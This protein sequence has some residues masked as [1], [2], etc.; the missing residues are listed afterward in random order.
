MKAYYI[1]ILMFSLPLIILVYNQRNH[2]ITTH[3][4]TNRSLC[5]CYLYMPNYYNDPQM[6]SVMKNFNK[7]TQQRFHEYDERLQEKRKQCKERCDKEIQKIILKDKLE[8][9]MAQQLT[10]L[11]PNI[12][13]EDI[14]TCICEKSLADKVEKVC[15]RCGYGLGSVAPSVGLF[16][17]LAINQY[18]N[19]VAAKVLEESIKKGIEVGLN[20]IA[21]ILKQ[22]WTDSFSVPKF[23]VIEILSSGYF[24]ENMT[25]FDISNYI[26]TTMYAKLNTD[27]YAVYSWG[28]QYI[29]MQPTLFTKKYP[30]E[31]AAVTDAVIKGKTQALNAAAP[32]TNSL[33]TAI[34]ASVIAI[35]VIVLIMMIIYLILRYRRKKKMKKKLQYIKLLEE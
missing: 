23:N 4:H 10:T 24:T 21:K 25:F 28:V 11:N 34:I 32:A 9:Q 35:V 6:K 16:G 27:N 20:S 26:N 18:T 8:K 30:T 13:T 5:E 14:P 2:Y 33:T 3:A 19:Y 29:T 7:Q 31:V 1:N 15:L 22:I 17:A 12:T